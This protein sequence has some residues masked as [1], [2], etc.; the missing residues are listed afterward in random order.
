MELQAGIACPVCSAELTRTTLSSA[1]VELDTCAQHGTWFDREELLKVSQ[2][3][4]AS[5]A[6][7]G[8]KPAARQEPT[9]SSPATARSS[10]DSDSEVAL[11]ASF[12]AVEVAEVAAGSTDLVGSAFEVLGGLFDG[13]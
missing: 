4:A 9:R 1:K 8:G 12:A 10:A 6:Y 11:E 3:H 2:S 7:G 5:R 13:L